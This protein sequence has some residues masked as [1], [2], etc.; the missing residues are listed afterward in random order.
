MFIGIA[1]NE[2][3]DG[4]ADAE[5]GETLNYVITASNDGDIA[6]TNVVV[7][8]SL[9]G[10]STTCPVV[11]VGGSCVLNA[12][13]VVTLDDVAA[14]NIANT[15]TADSD[16]TDPDSDD[17]DVPVVANPAY[18]ID[19][20]LVS[21][22]DEDGNGEVSL[23]DTLTYKVTVTNTGDIAMDITVSDSLIDPSSNSCSA[24]A[25]Q[26]G[27]CE[28]IGT[29]VVDQDDV[30]AGE[31][32][33]TG[34]GTSNLLDPIEDDL[35]VDVPQTVTLAIDKL[36]NGADDNTILA[37]ESVTWTYQVT[38]TGNTTLDS[39]VVTDSDP[40]VTVSCPATT[41][42]PGESTVCTASGTAVAGDYTNTGTA[43][44]DGPQD[45]PAS[46]SDNSGYFGASPSV[47][48]DKK[49]NGV[50]SGATVLEGEA[51]TWT[52]EV[53]NTGNVDL[54]GVV[55]SD[56]Q[57]GDVC[58][59]DLAVGE[60]TTCQAT[61]VAGSGAYDNTGSADGS[62]TDDSGNTTPVGDSDDSDYFGASPSVS[63]D[64]VTNGADGQTILEGS[65]VTWTYTVTNTGNVAL[66]DVVVSDDQEGAVCTVSLAVGESTTCEATG[67]AG[68]GAYSNTGSADTTFTD[69]S[70][71]ST[72]VGDT[73]D[74]DYFGASPSFTI[75]KVTTT[76]TGTGDGE[77][78]VAGDT[79]TWTYTVV[80]TGNVDLT[81]I[82]VT[83][84][85]EGAVC[86][87]DV[88]VGE[89]ATCTLDGTAIEGAYANTGVGDGTY[90]D[91]VGNSE[92]LND[93]DDSGYT[94]IN[95]NQPSIQFPERINIDP[96]GD[97]GFSSTITITNESD[98]L[99][100]DTVVISDFRIIVETGKGRNIETVDV[101][102]TVNGQSAGD[103]DPPISFTGESAD[104]EIE[105]VTADGSRLRGSY[106]IT[107]EAEI[108]N[109]DRVFS[110]STSVRF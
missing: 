110:T 29:Y 72:P 74:S 94:G 33:N 13:Y 90:T 53:T 10:E 60:S 69:D 105:C 22:A 86:T 9:T 59:V 61:G 87:V 58:T 56:D 19:K 98:R 39:L 62:Y 54:T 36:T 28:L 85:V 43:D 26:G 31:I 73:D 106:K 41:L 38:N 99:E 64:K 75:D 55:V 47:S 48:I 27:T 66:S 15:G 70:G 20:E 97:N 32:L 49:T 103:L 25:P 11:P 45:Q 63:I 35:T 37:G 46:G 71:N 83:D 42:A 78:A 104:F 24:V 6:L 92:D 16:E 57:E 109:R 34:T 82:V 107:F 30:D 68:S 51:V 80:N 21:N 23:N 96:V 12:S 93:T 17:E 76:S 14:G 102:C 18:T 44:A 5:L 77:F 7:S 108:L 101:N 84:S 88:A 67:T 52:Y 1:D 4:D 3:S 2:A 81:G 100:A 8:D 65:A 79:I 50:D 40:A 89:T 91:D 95:N